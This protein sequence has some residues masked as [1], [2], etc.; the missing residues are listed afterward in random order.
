ML[1]QPAIIVE[2]SQQPSTGTQALKSHHMH[3]TNTI[4][5]STV[6]GIILQLSQIHTLCS[7]AHR[8]AHTHTCS[9]AHRHAHTHTGGM[10]FKRG[11]VNVSYVY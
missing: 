9:H 4:Q 5:C 1:K 2:S 3:T 7:H 10:H 8:H 11:Y 6:A